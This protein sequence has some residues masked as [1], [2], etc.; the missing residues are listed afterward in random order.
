MMAALIAILVLLTSH[1]QLFAQSRTAT[2]SLE[3]RV[4]PEELLQVKDGSVRLK[5]RLA[6]GTIASV[7]AA[8]SCSSP[9][10]QSQVISASGTY[11]LSLH[12]MMAGISIA[13]ASA[14]HVCLASS[15]GT[16]NDSVPVGILAIGNGTAVQDRTSQL[17]P[18]GVTAVAPA[19]WSLTTQADTTTWSNP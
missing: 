2:I 9:S 1:I 17:A 4:S 14:A 13:N 3:L 16:L 18:N 7:W 11:T 8:N 19:G 5:I 12:T 10:P 15:D 6:P